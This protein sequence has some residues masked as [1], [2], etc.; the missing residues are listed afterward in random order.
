VGE[1]TQR[2]VDQS[3]M[4]KEMRDWLYNDHVC[5]MFYIPVTWLSYLSFHQNLHENLVQ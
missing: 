2:C 3:K 5:N 4:E 1:E